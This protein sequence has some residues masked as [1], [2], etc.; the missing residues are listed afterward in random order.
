MGI[1]SNLLGYF[2]IA[3]QAY[4]ATC[5]IFIFNMYILKHIHTHTKKSVPAHLCF[6]H[7]VQSLLFLF[8]SHIL[9]NAYFKRKYIHTSL[10][11][12]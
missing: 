5:L 10:S 2:H 12:H 8:F 11:T 6:I 7:S 9:L 4:Y 1:L 3:S